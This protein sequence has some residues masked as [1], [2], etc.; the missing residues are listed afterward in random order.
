M[1]GDQRVAGRFS[2]APLLVSAL[3]IRVLRYRFEAW[4][5][6]AWLLFIAVFGFFALVGAIF[7]SDLLRPNRSTFPEGLIAF[8]GALLTHVLCLYLVICEQIRRQREV[9]PPG[10]F[11]VII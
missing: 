10:G 6:I 7:V 5:V 4:V 9:P 8:W 11:E 1:H 2:V 3:L